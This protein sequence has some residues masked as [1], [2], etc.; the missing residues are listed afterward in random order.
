MQF[1]FLL[2]KSEFLL[3]GEWI[4]TQQNSRWHRRSWIKSLIRPFSCAK[5]TGNRVQTHL[6]RTVGCHWHCWW[7]NGTLW[8]SRTQRARSPPGCWSSPAPGTHRVSAPAREKR[9]PGGL[10]GPSTNYRGLRHQNSLPWRWV[11]AGGW[12]PLPIRNS[13]KTLVDW[14]SRPGKKWNH[15]RFQQLRRQLGD[16]KDGSATPRESAVNTLSAIRAAHK[17]RQLPLV[18][19]WD[20]KSEDWNGGSEEKLTSS[21]GRDAG[22]RERRV[23]GPRTE[24]DK[25]VSK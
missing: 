15:A 14:R 16:P 17:Y 10:T 25:R 1:V 20:L 24:Y 8:S 9:L 23:H 7:Y 2:T 5:P 12:R 3:Y 4:G 22:Q 6:M 19:M 11:L 21:T 13:Y 18:I